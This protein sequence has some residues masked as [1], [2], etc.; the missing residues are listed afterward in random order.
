M[1]LMQIGVL[2]YRLLG[3][4]GVLWSRAAILS[5]HLLYKKAAILFK[6]L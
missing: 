1:A 5:P 4:Q 3:T 2:L 6:L